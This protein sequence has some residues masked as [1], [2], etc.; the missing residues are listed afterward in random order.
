M[1][2]V[3]AALEQLATWRTR[4]TRASEQV[5]QNGRVVLESGALEKMGD[6]GVSSHARIPLLD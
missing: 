4:G 5:V 3:A 2:A 1:A 6:D